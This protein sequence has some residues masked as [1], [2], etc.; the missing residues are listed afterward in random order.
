MTLSFES[1]VTSTGE[2]VDVDDISRP[3][4]HT[5]EHFEKDTHQ[6]SFNHDK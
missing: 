5:F 3:L 1:I 6:D 4:T 2:V